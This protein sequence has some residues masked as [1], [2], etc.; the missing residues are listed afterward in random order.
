MF[1]LLRPKKDLHKQFGKKSTMAGNLL[2]MISEGEKAIGFLTGNADSGFDVTVGMFDGIARYVAFRK[3]SGRKWSEADLQAVM[4]QIG[5]LRNWT[6]PA[7]SDFLQYLER[8]G[9]EVVAEATGWQSPQRRYAFFYV[10]ILK[11][12]I[13][14]LPE[15]GALDQKFPGR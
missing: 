8:E 1:L 4:Q 7:N 12:E 3:R 9:N 11:E 6:R 13:G 10:P 2:N 15:K 5:P 14:L